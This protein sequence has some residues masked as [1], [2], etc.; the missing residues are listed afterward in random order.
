MA[1]FVKEVGRNYN[2]FVPEDGPGSG[3]VTSVGMSVPTGLSIS[4]TPIVSSGVL[5]LSYA[6]GYAIPTTIKQSN[7]D[8]AYTFVAAFPTQT[9]QSGKYLTTNGSALSWSTIAGS[10]ITGAALTETDDT[11]VTMT[12][13]GTPATALL[14]SVSMTLGWAGQLSV[15]R[16]GTGAN[17]L[18]GV[19]IGNLTAPVTAITGIGGQLLRANPSTGVYEFFTPAYMSNPM[20]SLGDIIYGNAAG[21]PNRLAAN[22]TGN[23][24]YLRSVSSGIPVWGSIAGA[25]ITGAAITTAND[26]N[27]QMTASGNTSSALLRTLTL[28]AGWSGQLAV[29]RGGTGASTLTGVVIGDGISTMV[30]VAGTAGQLLRRNA[31]NTAYEF[32]TPTYMA[33]V[34]TSLG[35]LVVSNAAGAPLRLAGNTTTTRKY[36]SQI[37]DGTSVVSTTWET[38]SGGGGGVTGSGTINYVAKWTPSGTALGNSQIF[39]NGTNV[40]IG[41]A[42]PLYKLDIEGTALLVQRI[43]STTNTGAAVLLAQN[44]LSNQYEAGIFGSTRTAVGA[45]ASGDAY[46]GS[47]TQSLVVFGNLIK[48][49]VGSGITEAMRL[50][51]SGNFGIGTNSPSTRLHL[52]ATGGEILRLEGG[53]GTTGNNYIGFRNGTTSLGYIGYGSAAE[54]SLTLGNYQ[55]APTY[56]VTNNLIRLTVSGSGDV[57]I[58][59]NPAHKLDVGGNIGLSGKIFAGASSIYQVIYDQVGNPSITIGDSSTPLIAYDNTSHVFRNRGGSV[60]FANISANGLIV[61]NKIIGGSQS[62]TNGSI[63]L[64]DSYSN[65]NLTNIGT[66][67]SSGA[68]VI[69]FA[70]TPSVSAVG[71]FV[72]AT[73]LTSYPRGALVV[74]DTLTYYSGVGQTV[75]IGS[76]VGCNSLFEILTTGQMKLTSYSTS[77]SFTGTAAGYLAFNS[78]GNVITVPVPSGGGTSA[79]RIDFNATIPDTWTNMPSAISF[80]DGSNAFITAADLTNFTQ[81]R[82]LINKLGTAGAAGSII[83]LRYNTSYTQNAN[84]WST[85]GTTSVQLGVNNTNQFLETAWIDLVAGAKADVFIALMG[86]GGDGAADPI[87]GMITAEFR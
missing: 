12:L 26:T 85:I 77:T 30:G 55:N 25:D 3:T 62:S 72:S 19:L 15:A 65:G 71:A 11:N 39:D 32:F 33:N 53:S 16:G 10:S 51:N 61:Y 63:I 75:A 7:W 86:S 60:G 50:T 69:G 41:I 83:I 68:P 79:Y 9:G 58:G 36:L 18:Q 34:F 29:G 43:R 28:T 45:V 8:D 82:L 47:S 81:V 74:A 22:S 27:V 35:D 21:A 44:D 14:R 76:A 1:R 20:T 31:L 78:S 40:G 57:G 84:L 87:F 37:G 42:S 80:Y 46:N 56:I 66:S 23:N 70:V 38:V 73:G 48:F 4:G 2:Q 64:Q 5:A 59:I 52:A 13:G 17:S 49:A 54:N 6:A 67:Y 24:M